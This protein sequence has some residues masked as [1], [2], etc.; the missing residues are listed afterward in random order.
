MDAPQISGKAL[1]TGASGFIG[2]RL[3]AALGKAGVEVVAIR[4]PGSPA[5][6]SGRSVEAS[7]DD[8]AGLTR[9]MQSEKPDYVLHVAGVTKG[10]TYEDFRS[11]NV[12]PTQNVL[13]ALRAC[14]HQVKR[15]VHFSSLAA[16]GPS[17]PERPH[18]E[19]DPRRPIEFY[20]QSKLEAEHVVEAE[21]E[22]PWT[23]LRPGG[24]FG[25]GDV[26]YFEL[27]REVERG[28]NVFFG[29]RER[30]FSAIYVDDMVDASLHATA[31]ADAAGK[32]FFVCDNAPI[33]WERFQDE[34][35]QASGKKA[36]TLNLPEAFVS[37]AAIGGEL[38]TRIDGKPRL[39]NRQK[40]KMGAQAAWTCKSD[41]LR[42]IGWSSRTSIEDGVKQAIAWYRAEKWM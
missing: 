2:S 20:G 1:I 36:R 26:D 33:T 22:I 4:R 34:I 35:V 23:I 30:L 39:M 12:M 38:I 3:K 31:H 32:G 7:Y 15:F 10:V 41:A 17:T 29:N 27:F 24:V 18:V 25:P 5:A 6:K 16:Y 8:L 28:R 40:A 13:T 37:I 21:R 19:S 42:G 11:G 14:D 9:V